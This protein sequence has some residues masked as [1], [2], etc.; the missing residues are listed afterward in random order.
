MLDLYAV[1]AALTAGGLVFEQH[2]AR[3]SESSTEWG[4]W[5]S[6]L[7]E[8]VLV[9]LVLVALVV[10]ACL[11]ARRRAPRG[12]VA[13]AFGLAGGLAVFLAMMLAHLFEDT[14]TND[15]GAV[16]ALGALLLVG[17]ALVLFV[18]E[19]IAAHRAREGRGP[20]L[21]D[22]VVT[23]RGRTVRNLLVV[24]LC[25][26]GALLA[27]LLV[28]ERHVVTPVD[29]YEATPWSE[30]FVRDTH[31]LVLFGP[32]AVVVTALRARRG[33]PHG[34]LAG[35]VAFVAGIAM[36]TTWFVM[37]TLVR[38]DAAGEWALLSMVGL[39]V[40]G[41][42][43]AI[44]DAVVHGRERRRTDQPAPSLPAARVSK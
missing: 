20:A 9:P 36:L 34:V 7:V 8:A 23:G 30:W 14:E 21:R 11:W 13:A 10:P 24:G 17:G 40:L 29:D 25:A 15:A 2:R 39:V 28:V 12:A 44:V 32:I 43:F 42:A 37:H 22:V 19:P 31:G 6:L 38:T 26:I 4:R 35:V 3:W 33:F 16:A 27:L 18:S 1:L 5:H 41:P